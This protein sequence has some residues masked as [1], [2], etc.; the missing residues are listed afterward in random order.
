NPDNVFAKRGEYNRSE[1]IGFIGLTG[2]GGFAKFVVV[3]DYMVHKIPNTVSF[4]QGALVERA[5]VAVHA[6][7]TSGLQVGMYQDPTVQSF[8]L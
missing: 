3:E 7:K 6:V 4:E 2:N 8:S 1:P 5:T